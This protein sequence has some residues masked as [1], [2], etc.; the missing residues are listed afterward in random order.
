MS[1]TSRIAGALAFA[2]VVVM[3]ATPTPGT[4]GARRYRTPGPGELVYKAGQMPAPE[5]EPEFAPDLAAIADLN[6]AEN[7]HAY[8][9][10]ARGLPV[11]H[12]GGKWENVGPLGHDMPADYPSGAF[13]F[14][15][16]AGMGSVIVVDP[17]DKS[18]N[19][20]YAGNMGGLW[21]STNAGEHWT[22]VSDKWFTRA[23]VGAIAVDKE[24][25]D[26][27]YVGTGIGY[28][29]TSGDAPGSGIW[30]SHDRGKTFH[31]PAQNIKGYAVH[32]MEVVDGDVIAGTSNG[33]YVSTNKGASFTRVP[34]PNNADHSGEAKGAYAN[35]ISAVQPSPLDPKEIIV[36]VGLAHGKRQG[37]QKE[38]LSPGNGLYRSTS[39]PAGPYEFMTSTEDLQHPAS[40]SDPVGRIMLS[41]VENP[42]GDAAVLWAIVSDAGLAYGRDPASADMIGDT[43]GANLNHTNTNLNGLYR[44]DDGGETWT[45]KATP[46]S[47]QTA[48]N[49]GLGYYPAL[50]Y[51]VGVQ[52]FY[53]LWV[54]A[55][56]RD[57]DQ[58]YFGLE[59]VFQSVRGTEEGPELGY[60]EIIQRY[61]DVCGMT[62]YVENLYPGRSCPDEL[63]YYGGVSTHP[64]Q[65]WG[66]LVDA[67]GKMRMY[68]AN[69][70]GYYWQDSHA[71][72]DGRN[73]YDNDGWIAMNTLA[74]V[75]PYKV[76]R[77]PD[78]EFLLALQDN[79]AGFFA[80]GETSKMVTLGDGV[81]AEATSD[82]DVFYFSYQGA[83]LYVT[84]DH[85]KTV[86][87]IPAEHA[88]APSFLS[89][90]AVDP[91]DDNH[92]VVA[93]RDIHESTKGADTQTTLDP[94][95]YTIIQTDWTQSFDA[96]T[97]PV[98]KT[99]YQAQAI[100]VRG[101]AVY[102]AICG[103]CRN[104]L[105][106]VS[107]VHATVATN[108]G[109]AGCE[110]KKA[111]K[112]CWHIA[113]GKGLPHNSIWNLAIDPEDNKTIYVALNNNSM[114]GY[115]PKVGGTQRVMVSH[116]AGKTF[117]DLTGNLPR[118][119]ARD[120]VV[121]DDQL[122]VAT[123]NGVFIA[124]K[125]GKTWSRL[126]AGLPAVR[127]NDLHLDPT[128]RYLTA[129]VYGRGVWSFDFN[130]T[131]KNSGGPGP[132]GEPTKPKPPAG[133]GTGIPAT[134]ANAAV[135]VIA[136]ALA[137]LAVATKRARRRA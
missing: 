73:A 126:G 36:A 64:D 100:A 110:P 94:V 105:G 75:Q 112:D 2:G 10:Q 86:R 96:G 32:D 63:P 9:L 51:G 115:D 5:H 95:L 24:N 62:T 68:T 42:S 85:G 3:L 38:P 66:T 56:P 119:Q 124:P 78:G 58:V 76:A 117:S 113:E 26:N 21:H 129:G 15:R 128:G 44:S 120:V 46:H 125:T 80:K 108:M 53:N 33:L 20:V 82:P 54:E 98:S 70:G 93:G 4:P 135:S 39:G 55:D 123:D 111:S 92:L 109:Q 34:L 8:E 50:G 18:G 71:L 65:H 132:K 11:K 22:N 27:L 88:S 59:E 114:V 134:G 97:S 72:P 87:A 137:T 81:N 17:A 41:Y 16:S 6:A 79:G 19:S 104:T 23:A 40:S 43:T 35:W 127:V 69:D 30:V 90:F 60:F 122:I 28:I 89:P 12:G 118:S 106:D 45:L 61:W 102:V 99:A 52:G 1:T 49:S 103:L 67:G 74:S 121:R 7:Q 29:T 84:T 133:P 13:R 37:P 31:R 57:P 47:L 25:P 83:M 107:Q 14:A 101:E 48:V 77:K 116:D 136:V 131:A 91:T 130:N